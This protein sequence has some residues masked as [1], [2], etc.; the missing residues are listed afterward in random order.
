MQL[1]WSNKSFTPG[2]VAQWRDGDLWYTARTAHDGDSHPKDYDCYSKKDITAF[3]R[4]DWSYVGV[5]VKA[6]RPANDDAMCEWIEV[7][8]ASLW[9]IE[10]YSS[11]AYITSVALDLAQEAIA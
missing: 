8:S 9:G 5:I 2:T 7:G 1:R 3:N 6:E 11:A 10:S 4:G